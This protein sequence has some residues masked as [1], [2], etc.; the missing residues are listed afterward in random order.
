MT[1]A[2]EWTEANYVLL[3]L[4][5]G[6]RDRF[7]LPAG[8]VEEL[9][10]ASRLQKFPHTTKQVDGVIVRRKRVVAVRDVSTLL[11]GRALAFHRFY[12]IVR[13][14]YGSAVELEAIPVSGDCELLSGV[15]PIPR[16][17]EA[18][19]Y[20]SAMIDLAGEQVPLLDLE[21]LAA[22]GSAA[23][24]PAADSVRRPA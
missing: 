2:S 17:E 6:G 5:P 19:E 3:R 9:A 16:A 22:A 11:T 12:L 15:I 7:A 1:I 13:R 8:D 4:G 21:K 10:G 18:P 24:T 20:F 14:R 23:D